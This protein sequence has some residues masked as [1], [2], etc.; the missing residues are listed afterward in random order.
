M[1]TEQGHADARRG[2][3]AVRSSM[4]D[5]PWWIED[6]GL[7][8]NT[9]ET[10]IEVSAD[11]RLQLLSPLPVWLRPGRNHVLLVMSDAGDRH[12]GISAKD[13]APGIEKT[14]NI[15]GGD[16][17]ISSTRIPVWTLEQSRRLGFSE[18]E[19][20]EAYPGLQGRDLLA[21]WDYVATHGVEIEQAIHDNE[22][23]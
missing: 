3:F 17:C 18:A 11:G 23:A 2:W 13:E 14:A 6:T 7:E 20:L 4:V 10:E 19:L 9:L 15:C 12:R 8:M 21:A 16:A 5:T 22:E 1:V